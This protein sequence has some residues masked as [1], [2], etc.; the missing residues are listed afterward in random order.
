MTTKTKEV[1]T[2]NPQDQALVAA[3]EQAVTSGNL[4]GLN[5]AQRLFYYNQVC[6]SVGLN[7]LTRPLDFIQLNGKLVLYAK[8][9][10][11]DQLRKLHTVSIIKIEQQVQEGCCVVTAYAK[12]KNGKEDSDMGAVPVAHLKGEAYANAIM[13]CVTKAKRRVTLSICGMGILDESELD[14][15]S[16]AVPDP[17]DMTQ[18]AQSQVGNIKAKVAEANKSEQAPPHDSETPPPVPEAAK[19]KP[20]EPEVVPAA[21]K[22]GKAALARAEAVA[23][24]KVE[25][26][27]APD[28]IAPALGDTKVCFGVFNG[29]ALKHLSNTQ[30]GE[31]LVASKHGVEVDNWTGAFFLDFYDRLQKYAASQGVGFPAEQP[32]EPAPTEAPPVNELE[33]FFETPFS[34]EAAKTS[35]DFQRDALSAIANAKDMPGL[36]KAWKQLFADCKDPLKINIATLPVDEANAF[37]TSANVAKDKRKA[38]IAAAKK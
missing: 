21:K 12:D 35:K 22:P 9:D 2:T 27:K 20:V 38:E 24:S 4:S 18:R 26:P 8:K 28:P 10:A 14:T 11:T 32:T 36:E 25:A 16:G 31:L 19:K 23:A 29:K 3:V 17:I 6:E 34:E 7:P 37:K 13:K 15:V 30:L 33:E 5:P 1:T